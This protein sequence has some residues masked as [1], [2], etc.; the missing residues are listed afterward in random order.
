[1]H[2]VLTFQGRPSFFFLVEGRMI[3]VC[4]GR[5]NF[6]IMTVVK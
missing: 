5:I 4:A 2:S 1:M 6:L 3:H